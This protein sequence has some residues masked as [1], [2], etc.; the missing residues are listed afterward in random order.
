MTPSGWDCDGIFVPE[1]RAVRQK[2][3]RTWRGPVA[4]KY[5]D[6]MKFTI[7]REGTTYIVP[8]NQGIFH[9][10]EIRCPSLYPFGVCWPIPSWEQNRIGL[11]EEVPHH[12]PAPKNHPQ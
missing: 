10:S 7:R 4:V 5:M 11:L 6:F 12:I 3:G 1:D 2:F 8:A 9:S